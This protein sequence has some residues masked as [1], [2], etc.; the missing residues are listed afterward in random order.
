MK[1]VFISSTCND[2][3]K[4]REIVSE[5]LKKSDLIPVMSNSDNFNNDPFKE[6]HDA[7]L[8]EIVDCDAIIVLIGGE[9]GKDYRGISMKNEMTMLKAKYDI[10]PSISWM[11]L[12]CA[13]KLNKEVHVIMNSQIY[14]EYKIFCAN[15]SKIIN[16]VHTKDTRIFKLIKYI[17]NERRWIKFYSTMVEFMNR[18]KVICDRIH[19]SPS[20]TYAYE[21]NK[22]MPEFNYQNKKRIALINIFS[23]WENYNEKMWLLK[24]FFFQ[25]GCEAE[26]I[27]LKIGEEDQIAFSQFSFVIINLNSYNFNFSC[28]MFKAFKWYNKE[29]ITI[30]IGSFAEHNIEYLKDN[31]SQ[32]IDFIAPYNNIKSI[33]YF[34]LS[35]MNCGDVSNILTKK[36][37]Y[38]EQAKINAKKYGDDLGI[39]NLYP[40]ISLLRYTQMNKRAEDMVGI[41]MSKG[42][43]K[44]CEVCGISLYRQHSIIQALDDA[45]VE[46][47]SYVYSLGIRRIKIC[48]EDIFC[49]SYTRIEKIF[50]FLHQQYSD[51]EFEINFLISEIDVKK[52]I[53]RINK[54]SRYGLRK[55]NY[56]LCQE[57]SEDSSLDTL[58]KMIR[59]QNNKINSK[60]IVYLGRYVETDNYYSELEQLIKRGRRS[61]YRDID[62]DIRFEIPQILDGKIMNNIDY[63]VW[64]KNIALFDYKKPVMSYG[65]VLNKNKR[66]NS[67]AQ[68]LRRKMLNVYDAASQKNSKLNPIIPEDVKEGF[69][70]FSSNYNGEKIEIGYDTYNSILKEKV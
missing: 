29:L 70:S 62:W 63:K 69:L 60:V 61:C 17:N 30:A 13:I 14:E 12:V 20:R 50:Y 10:T 15:D 41:Y 64:T 43:R 35:F 26:I 31:F 42:C 16:F 57:N 19:M 54:L 55:V 68:D 25:R 11:E 59:N 36:K 56:F 40:T 67:S 6:N 49:C 28:E 44:N 23:D 51:I 47:I 66:K 18:L 58:K 2:L 34:T 1:K 46:Y 22:I 24:S 32:Y 21:L 39:L 52:Q 37:I 5:C 8:Q 33:C 3:K 9:Y 38:E 7:C 45:V 65:G 48:D 53:Q 4:E 27:D